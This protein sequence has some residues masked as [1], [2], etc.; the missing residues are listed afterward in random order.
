MEN[1]RSRMQG[2]VHHPR[3]SILE[4]RP[5]PDR[6]LRARL[7]RFQPLTACAALLAF[8]SPLVWSAGRAW[9]GPAGVSA[10]SAGGTVAAPWSAPGRSAPF[11]GDQEQHQGRALP[12]RSSRRASSRNIPCR[13]HS[14]CDNSAGRTTAVPAS[15][16]S[17]HKQ[18]ADWP[19]PSATSNV[20]GP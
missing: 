8:N 1:R 2:V 4:P 20:H 19:Q 10:G 18:T 16:S 9:S 17:S 3:S 13:C 6:L 11:L 12:R 5:M 14:H 15:N 7:R